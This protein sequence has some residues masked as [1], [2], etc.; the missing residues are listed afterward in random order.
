M[1]AVALRVDGSVRMGTGHLRRCMA[2]A[3]E[4]LACGAKPFFV[5]RALD[6]TASQV[7]R[8][9]P[10]PVLW[11]PEFDSLPPVAD[12]THWP[13]MSETDDARA[14]IDLCRPFKPAWVVVDHYDLTA[15]WHDAVGGALG[16]RVAVIDDLANRPLACD[17]LVDHN[18]H[19]DHDVKYRTQ[20]RRRPQLL[21][22]PTYALL[23]EQYRGCAKYC[24]KPEVGSIGIFL[25]GTDPDNV[26]ALAARCCRDAGFRGQIEVAATSASPH[27]VALRTAAEADPLLRVTVDQANLCSFFARHD[28]QIGAGGG[29]SWERCCVGCPSLVLLLA[30]NQQAVV[31]A[32]ESTGVGRAVEGGAS[33]APELTAAIGDMLTHPH[34]RLEMCVKGRA[35]V[36]GWGACRVAAWLTG[37]Q[38][39]PLAARPASAADEALLLAW[40][41]DGTVRAQ[42]FTQGAI[43]ASDHQ[44]WLGARLAQPLRSRL[45][46]VETP[47]GLPVGQVRFDRTEGAGWRI[48]Y[49]VDAALR[50]AGHGRPLLQCAMEA[51]VRDLAAPVSLLA[52]VKPDNAPSRAVFARSGFVADEPG[53]REGED[54]MR[55]RRVFP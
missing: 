16:A 50:G 2:L 5:T 37:G 54:R 24:F 29:A 25:G 45:Y 23:D 39:L 7:L 33:L 34:A 10:A 13:A 31:P 49:S 17:L 53:P 51:L 21:G 28:L 47:A 9:A 43:P 12:A 42:S 18:W 27:L 55:F 35:L 40:A 52:E 3:K 19:P 46:I 48:N 6:G 26:A 41:N 15:S 11:R 22:G 44:R 30:E 4:L 8:D 20:L 36:D 1:T 14:T 32:L 38:T